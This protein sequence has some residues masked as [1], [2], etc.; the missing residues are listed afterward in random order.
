MTAASSVT[1]VRSVCPRSHGRRPHFCDFAENIRL[2]LDALQMRVALAAVVVDAVAAKVF[3]IFHQQLDRLAARPSRG[4]WPRV[5]VPASIS[6]RWGLC[7]IIPNDKRTSVRCNRN[8]A[9]LIRSFI[10]KRSYESRASIA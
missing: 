2:A 8:Q 7:A 10:A 4:G 9:L 3:F 5:K 1:P 6:C